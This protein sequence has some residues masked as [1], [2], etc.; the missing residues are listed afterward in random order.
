[1]KASEA[2]AV[3]I[4]MARRATHLMPHRFTR[5]NKQTIA[6]ATASTGSQGRYHCWMAEA[7]S[8][9]VSPQVGTQPHQ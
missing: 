3:A 5:L 1:M 4:G 8:R 2:E 6:L 7:E 9:A